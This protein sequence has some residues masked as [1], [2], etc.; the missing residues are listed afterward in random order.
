MIEQY[1]REKRFF[2]QIGIS[3]ENKSLVP[4]TIEIYY[5]IIENR[6]ILLT[7]G[8]ASLLETMTFQ[9]EKNRS[10]FRDIVLN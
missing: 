1:E 8:L 7:I 4:F 6:E 2:K 10:P 9:Q 3:N 5:F